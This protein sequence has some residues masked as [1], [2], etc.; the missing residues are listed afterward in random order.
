MTVLAHALLVGVLI[1]PDCISVGEQVFD[2]KYSIWWP[3]NAGTSAKFYCFL[4]GAHTCAHTQPS[5]LAFTLPH[6]Y[7]IIVFWALQMPCGTSASRL[8]LECKCNFFSR[9]AAARTFHLFDT[10]SM[11]MHE[12]KHTHTHKHNPVS[13]QRLNIRSV[14]L[15]SSV[16]CCRDQGRQIVNDEAFT[17]RNHIFQS[18]SLHF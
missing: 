2:P 11:C 7:C 4:L 12:P 18:V 10:D 5:V 1:S 16:C 6:H 9:K 17:L 13:P 3:A 15:A 8:P 14:T